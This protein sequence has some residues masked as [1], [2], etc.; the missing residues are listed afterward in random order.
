[1][2]AV[3]LELTR[4]TM[5]AGLSH[6]SGVSYLLSALTATVFLLEA[7]PGPVLYGKTEVSVRSANR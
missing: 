3:S 1:M 7:K 2:P 4:Q 5:V 6:M